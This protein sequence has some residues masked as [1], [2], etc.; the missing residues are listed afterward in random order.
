MDVGRRRNG[1]GA[2]NEPVAP[3]GVQQRWSKEP[4]ACRNYECGQESLTLSASESS[5]EE[6]KMNMTESWANEHNSNA[7]IREILGSNFDRGI[8]YTYVIHGF[9]QSLHGKAVIVLR[10]GHEILSDS[11]IC[12]PSIRPYMM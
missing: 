6:K 9:P 7:L 4:M 10:F 2:L 12:H 3:V 1:N 8:D 11:F 5:G